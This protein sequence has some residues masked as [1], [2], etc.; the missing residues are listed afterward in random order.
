MSKRQGTDQGRHLAALRDRARRP[1]V[2]DRSGRGQDER[3]AID[4]ELEL[5]DG[6][7]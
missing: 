3:S 1:D 7:E 6:D 4:A 5:E 2:K